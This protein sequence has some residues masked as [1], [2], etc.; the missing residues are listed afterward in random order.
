MAGPMQRILGQLVAANGTLCGTPITIRNAGTTGN[1]D[2]PTVATR[3]G[4]EFV[5][6]WHDGVSNDVQLRRC[7]ITGICG[8]QTTTFGAIKAGQR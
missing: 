4:V 8:G 7:E 5:V 2:Q 1:L 6:G 3:D